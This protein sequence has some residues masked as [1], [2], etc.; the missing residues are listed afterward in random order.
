MNQATPQEPSTFSDAQLRLL[1][2]HLGEAV[3]M[4]DPQGCVESWTPAA[5]RVFSHSRTETVGISAAQLYDGDGP[6]QLAASMRLARE[7]GRAE[8]DAWRLRG[9][10][11]RFWAHEVMC[12]ITG[13]DGGNAGYAVIVRDLSEL[14]QKELILEEHTRALELSNRE[15]EEF[16]SIASHDLQEPLRKILAFGDRLMIRCE[17]MLDEK[18]ADYLQRILDTSQRMRQLIDALLNYS[19]IASKKEPPRLVDMGK[20]CRQV[21]GD[22]ENHVERSGAKVEIGELPCLMAEPTQMRQLLQN[23]I[24][25]ALKFVKPGEAPRVTL[26]SRALPADLA[27]KQVCEIFVEDHGIGFDEKYLKRIFGMLERLHSRDEYEG[28]GIGLAICRRI[29]ERHGGGITAKSTPG[30]GARFTVT[31]KTVPLH[32]GERK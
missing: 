9:G 19:R 14:R 12:L 32:A 30:H 8:G 26:G 21:L 1:F 18:G 6:S 27:G 20:L 16:A 2:T 23:L 11:Q 7:T 5:Q 4:L 31:L 15:L 22:L 10:G 13:K 28:T 3:F 24:S 17:G 25:N 29:A